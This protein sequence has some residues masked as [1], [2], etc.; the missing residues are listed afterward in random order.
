MDDKTQKERLEQ[1]LRFLKESFEAEVIS[2]DEFEK[3]KD[4]VEK[5]L[6][7]IKQSEELISEERNAE[8]T[9]EKQK[10]KEEQKKEQTTEKI[11]ETKDDKAIETK[12]S[13]KIKLRVFQDEAEEHNHFDTAQINAD[14][15]N[16]TEKPVY[17]E[18]KKSI[19]EKKESKFFKYAVVLVV[20]ILVVFF[21]YS[22]LK[23]NKQS[24]EK[25]PQLKFVAVCSSND[26]CKQQGKEGFCLDPGTKDAKC[27]FKD[28][29][30]INLIVLNDRK[31]CFNCDT[32]RVFNI[33][34]S[35]FGAINSKE[36]DYNTAEGKNIAEKFSTKLLPLYILSE[37][38][39]RK[40]QFEKF[41]KLFVKKDNMYILNE[42]A[43]GSIFYFKRD[44][45]PNTLDLFVIFG[46]NASIRA[47]NNLKEFLDTFKEI[48][49]SKHLSSDAL[50]QE[51]GIKTF[52]AFLVNNR[53]KLS[54]V[55]TAEDIKNNFCKLNKLPDCK[56][57][58]SKNLI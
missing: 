3:G 13:E 6:K 46:D 45:I 48:K 10:S 21:S 8:Q 11:E 37:N 39:T 33:L 17:E 16:K 24:Q 34:E 15:Q 2:K 43:S 5:K 57:G 44:N 25:A 52:P 51:L 53:I 29:P 40:P 4:R 54:G 19:E 18:S 42:D 7:E 1:E 50:A 41:S 23:E 49:F 56:K 55:Y 27:E 9:Q 20:L 36:I 32:Q 22:L 31:D 26:D 38:V 12:T 35:W 14:I 30:K 47:E 28:I 58:L